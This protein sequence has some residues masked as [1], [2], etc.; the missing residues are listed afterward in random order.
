MPQVTQFLH[1]GTL[2]STKP[3]STFPPNQLRIWTREQKDQSIWTPN[4]ELWDWIRSILSQEVL[5]LMSLWQH[6]QET[7]FDLCSH[8][9][10]V[11]LGQTGFQEVCRRITRQKMGPVVLTSRNHLENWLLNEV[12]QL[13]EEHQISKQVCDRAPAWSV[14]PQDVWRTAPAFVRAQNLALQLSTEDTAKRSNQ[15]INR[16]FVC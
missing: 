2:P 13:Y 16:C 11:S 8:S 4:L 1:K 10:G 3:R 14:P 7:H 15:G 5:N 12:M 9:R 6:T